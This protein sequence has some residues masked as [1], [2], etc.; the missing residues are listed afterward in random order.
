[1]SVQATSDDKD[2]VKALKQSFMNDM[3]EAAHGL[4]PIVVERV[5]ADDDLEQQRKFL[6]M[7]VDVLGWKQAQPKDA[8]DNLPVFQFNFGPSGMTAQVSKQPSQPLEMVEEVAVNI[9]ANT[10]ATT[11][12]D[13]L[14]ALDE[15]LSRAD[16]RAMRIKA[17]KVNSD[18]AE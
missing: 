17:A 12:A 4:L 8:Y 16:T 3:A 5:L 13:D 15:A 10:D 9:F 18:V 1:M 14:L 2:L 11:D 6:T 7:A